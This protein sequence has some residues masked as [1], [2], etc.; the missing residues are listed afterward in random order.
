MS[1]PADNTA[2]IVKTATSVQYVGGAAA[3]YFGLTFNELMAAIGAA[4]AVF[5]FFVNWFYTHK[6]YKLAEKS[7][8]GAELDSEQ[9]PP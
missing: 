1:T 2:V 8:K 6:R 3:V 9:G 7:A 5:G 4:A